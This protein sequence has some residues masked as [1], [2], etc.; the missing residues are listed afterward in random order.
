MLAHRIPHACSHGT[1]K[2]PVDPPSYRERKGQSQERDEHEFRR[3]LER[4]TT[5]V[6]AKHDGRNVSLESRE[7]NRS[8]LSLAGLCVA[9][10]EPYAGSSVA[11]LLFAAGELVLGITVGLLGARRGGS[12]FAAVVMLGVAACVA[13]VLY[14]SVTV[15]TCPAGE[16]CEATTWAN[17]TWLALALV[18]LWLLAVGMGYGLADR[19]R[20]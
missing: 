9:G 6:Q 4:H 20:R 2:E 1:A 14:A 12:W 19:L 10:G 18:G 16:D 17:W 13:V 11:N 8:R 7:G 3:N 15:N 5:I